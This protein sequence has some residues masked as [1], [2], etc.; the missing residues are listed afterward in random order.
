[1]N[2]PSQPPGEV[3]N[4]LLGEDDGDTLSRPEKDE[5]LLHL[6]QDDDLRCQKL[7]N[8]L[9]GDLQGL[10][11]TVGDLDVPEQPRVRFS[12][13]QTT[14]SDRYLWGNK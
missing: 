5:D 2:L 7:E 6:K 9:E 14:W 8:N 11:L 1:M 3:L 13:L 4:T 10:T 12:I